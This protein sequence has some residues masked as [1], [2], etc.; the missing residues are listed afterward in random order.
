MNPARAALLTPPSTSN[1]IPDD[2]ELEEEPE[3]EMAPVPLVR[4]RARA[5]VEA[6]A[7]RPRAA[8]L[9]LSDDAALHSTIPA[10]GTGATA[11]APAELRSIDEEDEDELLIEGTSTFATHL[12]PE[13]VA[14]PNV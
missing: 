12:S 1:A 9:H 13:R 8:S 7:N 3:A 6:A 5:R 14:G 11:P 2:D 10:G 4:E